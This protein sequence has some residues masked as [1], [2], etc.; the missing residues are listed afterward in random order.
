MKLI[1]KEVS[2]KELKVIGPTPY[3][4]RT[5]LYVTVHPDL[6]KIL[7]DRILVRDSINNPFHAKRRERIIKKFNKRLI[8]L[9]KFI[10]PRIFEDG[11]SAPHS[12]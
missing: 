2:W 5:N 7:V 6:P 3:S 4:Y 10:E 8:E 9:K 12:K 11:F 1:L